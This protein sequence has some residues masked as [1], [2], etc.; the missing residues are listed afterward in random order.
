MRRSSSRPAQPG[1]SAECMGGTSRARTTLSAV[2]SS[3]TRRANGTR[4]AAAIAHSVSTLGFALPD[5][6]CASVDLPS[7]A[8]CA[9][10]SRVSPASSR[11]ARTF[12]ATARTNE[13]TDSISLDTESIPVEYSII[14]EASSIMPDGAAIRQPVAVAPRE[15][16]VAG[17]RAVL[18][19]AIAVL[20][21]G[22]S[23]GILA[24]DAGMGTV[25]PIVM[26]LTTFAGLGAVR[27]RVGARVRRGGRG[28]DR[29]GGDAQHALPRRRDVGRAVFAGR[30]APPP[31]RVAQLAVDESWAVAQSDGRVDRDRLIGAGLVLMT[32]WC[33]G[34]VLGVV[35][36]G[37][38]GDPADYGLDAMFPALFLALLVGQLDGAP[39][40]RRGPGRGPDRARAH[41]AR[42]AGPADRGRGRRRRRR[43]SGCGRDRASGS[44]SPRSVSPRSAL[45][46]AGPVVF[47][48]RP[49]PRTFGLVMP[50]LA[51][52]LLAALVVGQTVADGR[53]VVVDARAGGRRC[54]RGRA[55]V[56]G[57]AV[58]GAG[59]WRPA[60]PLRL[61]RWAPP[62]RNVNCGI[63]GGDPAGGR[64]FW[65]PGL[66]TFVS[67]PRDT[68]LL[69]A[70]GSPAPPRPQ[71]LRARE[72]AARASVD[73][74]ERPG[75]NA[76]SYAPHHSVRSTASSPNALD[77][78]RRRRVPVQ[79]ERRVHIRQHG[80]QRVATAHRHRRGEQRRRA[81]RPA[82]RCRRA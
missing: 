2:R 33:A 4:S 69:N 44:R 27:G 60:W 14:M 39:R 75:V 10:S 40:P 1:V 23:F 77:R 34:T 80:A 59:A 79:L 72:R 76:H 28:G 70:R 25:A 21:F 73:D 8:A 46:G 16:L 22:A 53:A 41:A 56:A 15:G 50:L 19:I 12:D 71:V 64:R 36:G 35:G 26:S 47:A 30:Q 18:P 61:A 17:M 29:R 57:A 9:R 42:A 13:S 48:D 58:G 81:G 78:A 54:G 20:A 51:P 24:R 68:R 7:P 6:S 49:L 3:S 66:T 67:H 11:S 55:G 5:S 74:V 65:Q 43:R 37:A 52:C 32:A 63:E 82:G 31:A 38:L 45:K 62:R